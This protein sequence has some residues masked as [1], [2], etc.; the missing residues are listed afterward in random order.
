MDINEIEAEKYIDYIEANY[1]QMAQ[2]VNKQF[3]LSKEFIRASII[4]EIKEYLT[5]IPIHYE[6]EL[7]DCP[8]DYSGII[9]QDGYISLNQT[10]SS[11][12]ENEYTGDKE[13]TYESGMGFKY[14]T[15]G[16]KLE[17]LTRNIGEEIL[18]SSVKYQLE[19]KF[20]TVISDEIFELV[21]DCSHDKVD[22]YCL[23]GDFFFCNTAIDFV[24]I[25][26]MSLRQIVNKKL[27]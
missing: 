23:S 14:W 8:Y 27:H 22:D 26:D 3:E 11:F 21:M 1:M 2:N 15:Y 13:A 12:L 16:D 9:I 5:P 24:G 10:V 18:Q 17:Y 25:G 6:W 4:R 19:Q 20:D 7:D